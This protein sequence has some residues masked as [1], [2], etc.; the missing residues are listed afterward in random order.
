VVLEK[1]ADRLIMNLP[2]SAEKY[3]DVATKLAKPSGAIV[4]FL[5]CYRR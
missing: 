5:W 4:H 1:K 3:L 2:F